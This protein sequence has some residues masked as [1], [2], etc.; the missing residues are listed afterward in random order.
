MSKLARLAVE[1]QPAPRYGNGEIVADDL[2]RWT[3]SLE[4]DPVLVG[5]ILARKQIGV[6]RYGQALQTNDGRNNMAD[7]VQELLDA[8]IYAHKGT[9][10]SEPN[11]AA[12]FLYTETRYALGFA[13]MTIARLA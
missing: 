8:L 1:E 3:R 10:E 11:T 5:A 6:E 7:M 2:A 9:M 12:W 13:L 4:E